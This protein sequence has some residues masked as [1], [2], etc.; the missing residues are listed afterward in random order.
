MQR[1][2]VIKRLIAAMAAAAVGG[3]LVLAGGAGVPAHAGVSSSVVQVTAAARVVAKPIKVR[4]YGKSCTSTSCVEKQIKKWVTRKKGHVVNLDGIFGGQC[5]DLANA[6]VRQVWGT[7][8]K[9]VFGNAAA[10]WKSTDARVLAKFD[11]VSAKSTPRVGDIAVWTYG[12]GSSDY[13]HVAVVVRD[14]TT[15]GKYWGQRRELVRVIQQNAPKGSPY[16][17]P[18]GDPTNVSNFPTWGLAGYLRPV[19]LVE[20]TTLKAPTRWTALKLRYGVT[21]KKLRALNPA[22]A[23]KHAVT[24]P[25]GVSVKIRTR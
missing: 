21:V 15:H 22:L 6:Y 10:W 19:A 3:M 4:V 14:G 5:V 8:S 24:L 9:W 11:R 2:S 13:G 25:A 18:T 20:H 23:K 16:G 12:A 17:A 1:T 7:G